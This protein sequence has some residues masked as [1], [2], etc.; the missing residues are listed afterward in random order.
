MILTRQPT[1]NSIPLSTMDKGTLFRFR[2]EGS[3]RT[4]EQ[5]LV[6]GELF[7]LLK[8]EDAHKLNCKNTYM[9]MSGKFEFVH[10]Y[11]PLL[12]Q[13]INYEL[14][15]NDTYNIKTLEEVEPG[16]VVRFDEISTY[17]VATN[18][19][20]SEKMVSVVDKNGDITR[21]SKEAV[22]QVLDSRFLIQPF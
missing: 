3:T 12:G 22:C 7:M 10:R 9:R 18:P 5:D 14:S 11:G 1:S 2:R 6:E 17:I 21:L 20:E 19:V 4:F 13:P 15:T 16:T 8:T